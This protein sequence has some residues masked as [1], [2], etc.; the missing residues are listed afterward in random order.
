MF[1]STKEKENE[2]EKTKEK[3]KE[4]E[5]EKEE[6]KENENEKEKDKTKEKEKENAKEKEEEKEKEM[7]NE[8]TETETET[9]AQEQYDS[10]TVLFNKKPETVSKRRIPPIKLTNTL[11]EK[12][13]DNEN[14]N[15]IQKNVAYQLEEGLYVP[16]KGTLKSIVKYLSN[17][18]VYKPRNHWAFFE[19]L[20]E[21]LHARI[22]I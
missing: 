5:K 16:K 8:K 21:F 17:G 11:F 18:R 2:K 7:G 22:I 15:E 1:G 6:E 14:G 12:D 13:K 20:S 10:L 3:E 9:E 4:N 19:D